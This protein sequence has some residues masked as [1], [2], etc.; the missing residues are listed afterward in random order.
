MSNEFSD[1]SITEKFRT[2]DYWYGFLI[3][4]CF[5]LGGSL[6]SLIVLLVMDG[7]FSDYSFL[8]FFVILLHLGYLVLWPSSA[9]LIFFQGVKSGNSLSKDGALLSLKLYGLW[10]VVIIAP[11]AWFA[12]SLTGLYNLQLRYKF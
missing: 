3:P 10:M 12:T 11:F 4:L 2:S 5:G 7:Q 6:F 8:F 1:N 9:V